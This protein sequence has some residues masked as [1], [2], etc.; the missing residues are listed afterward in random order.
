[1]NYTF[2]LFESRLSDEIDELKNTPVRDVDEDIFALR[3]E[4]MRFQEEL[5]MVY[6]ERA[7]PQQD[8]NYQQNVIQKQE[9]DLQRQSETITLLDDEVSTG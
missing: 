2:N 6:T 4:C 3:E 7:N 1:M 8:I 9:Y 5:N